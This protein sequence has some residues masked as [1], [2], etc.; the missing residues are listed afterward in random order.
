[1]KS[2]ASVQTI[3]EPL[4]VGVEPADPIPPL[5]NINKS[6]SVGTGAATLAKESNQLTPAET[7]HQFKEKGNAMVKQV[8]LV[9][10]AIV[11]PVRLVYPAIAKQ[12]RLVYP[13][14]VRPVRCVYPVNCV[15]KQVRRGESCVKQI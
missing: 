1:M 5:V 8:R 3:S 7:F 11:K 10:P 2:R 13:A 9:Y 12:V 14:I 15:V 4:I 6:S